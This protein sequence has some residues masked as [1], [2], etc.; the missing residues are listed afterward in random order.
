MS[1]RYVYMNT[2]LWM[3]IL[4]TLKS[5]NLN[6]AQPLTNNT[7]NAVHEQYFQPFFSLTLEQPSFVWITSFLW[8]ERFHE[9]SVTASLDISS[10][11]FPE[12]LFGGY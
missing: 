12:Q 3:E 9:M 4:Q 10:S 8:L 11:S 1:T 6:T 2:K 5:H 7:P